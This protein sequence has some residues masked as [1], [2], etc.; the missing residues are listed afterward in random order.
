MINFNWFLQFFFAFNW[1]K[2][3][4]I[5]R[6]DCWQFF[7]F[8]KL[9]ELKR[10]ICYIIIVNFSVNIIVIFEKKYGQMSVITFRWILII[11]TLV[12]RPF[13]DWFELSAFKGNFWNNFIAIKLKAV[14]K[15]LLV[16]RHFTFQ[17]WSHWLQVISFK[18]K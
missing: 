7:L 5:I 14:I 13:P 4:F 10:L 9:F 2:F 1:T 12:N 15:L 16:L 18:R 6:N 11:H 17:W 3:I 8:K